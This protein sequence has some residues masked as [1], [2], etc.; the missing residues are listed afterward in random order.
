MNSYYIFRYWVIMKKILFVTWTRADYWKLKPLIQAIEMSNFL[1][2]HVFVT[3]MHIDEKY[4]FT[5][6]EILRSQHKNIFLNDKY[7]KNQSPELWLAK[8]IESLS[9]YIDKLKFDAI[10]VHWDRPDALAWAIAWSFKNVMVIHIE[11]WE[12]SWSIDESIRHSVSKLSHLH[13]VSN[14]ECWTNLERM[15]ESKNRIYV[16]WSP[17]F[18]IMLS[19]DLPLITDLKKKHNILFDDY[20]IFLFHPVTTEAN[21]IKNNTLQ[22]IQWLVDSKKNFIIIYPNNDPWSKIIYE[23]LQNSIVNDVLNVFYKVF[24]SLDFE[25]FVTLLK[26]SKCIVW[27]SSCWVR[28][29]PALWIPSIN[30]WSRQ[31][32]RNDRKSIVNVWYNQDKITDSILKYRESSFDIK[33]YDVKFWTWNSGKRFREI[34][35]KESTREISVQK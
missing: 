33:D 10:V 7:E 26:N 32:N 2:S 30:I 5:V 34:L 19:D 12:S 4:W 20:W 22:V 6:N 3:W 8:L 18:D 25:D 9:I 14:K 11:W 31:N 17:E 15:W 24:D 16:I 23:N 29:A 13:F 27:N 28:Q 1:D 35:E 21:S